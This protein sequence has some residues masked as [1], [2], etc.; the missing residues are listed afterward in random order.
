MP[1]TK[2]SLTLRSNDWSNRSKWSL[3]NGNH[4]QS[5]QQLW[6]GKGNLRSPTVRTT[7]PHNL[8][9]LSAY[10]VKR[11]R[12]FLPVAKLSITNYTRVMLWNICRKRCWR[13]T[14]R[15]HFASTT[16]FVALLLLKCD[17]FYVAWLVCNI[18]KQ[19]LTLT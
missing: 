3:P 15:E 8:L 6:W 13:K 10:W 18:V 2:G 5:T 17:F 11:L 9:P 16:T 4:V 7:K 19:F 14:K 1:S 12:Q